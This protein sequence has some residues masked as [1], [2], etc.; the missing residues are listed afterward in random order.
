[1]RLRTFNV[2]SYRS[3]VDATLEDVK[4]YCAIVGPNNA[5]KS[6]LLRAIYVSL[7]IALEGDFQRARRNRQFSYAYNGENYNWERDIPASL[8]NDANAST[9][10]KLTFE[11]SDEEKVEFKERFSI[12]LSKS[13]QMKFQ[14]FRQ[15]TEYNIIM[16]GRAKRPMEEKIQEIGLF[17]RSKLDYQYIPCVRST[18]FTSEYFSRLLNKE[19]RQLE[20]D[21]EYKRCIEKIQELQTPLIENLETRLTASL[22]TFLPNVQQVKLR[23]GI[24]PVEIGTHIPYRMRQAPIDID[25]G[26]ITSIEDKG[27][28]VKSLAAIGIV[29]SLSFEN[30][31]DKALILCIEEPEAHLHSDAI[32]SL[33][34]VILEIASRSNVQVIIST[35]SPILVDRDTVSNNIVIFDNHR[36]ASC[37]SISEV[38][39]VLGVRMADNLSAA[40]VVLVEGESE[41]R[42]LTALCNTLHP[43]IA[44]KLEHNAL[45][46]V[47]V[48]SASKMEYQVRLYNSLMISSLVL[49][50]S[51]DSGLSSQEQLI[52]SKTKLPGEI[53]MIKSAG[54]KVCELEDIVEIG[55][56][57][58]AIKEKFNIELNTTKFRKRKKVWSDRLH[59][60]AAVSPGTFN[61]NV[62]KEIKTTIADIV[63]NQGI[64]AIASYD[65]EYIINLINAIAKFVG[66]NPI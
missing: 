30:A 34:N 5:G 11:F 52:T 18:E 33:R 45:E 9:T 58:D 43:G 53:L 6:N 20:N 2:K 8:K 62:E 24:S 40:K 21:Q 1:M 64:T 35:H 46:I 65:R 39:D 66:E 61:E 14:L 57:S 50:D 55:T 15:Q 12:N 41:L 17:I 48:H 16:P 23:G 28:G 27:D 7:S 32:H 54:M 22:K 25:D 36:V 37:K 42:Y 49:L 56:Y 38:R 47:N 60:A 26:N 13:L 44:Y 51:D 63:V 29:Q 31:K 59:D 19:L 10:F 4:H 3:I